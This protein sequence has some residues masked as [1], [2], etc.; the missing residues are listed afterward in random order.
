MKRIFSISA[1]IIGF[2][3]V[4]TSLS[5]CSEFHPGSSSDSWAA[6]PDRPFPR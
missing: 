2:V 4:A 5:A 3:L 1:A 6:G